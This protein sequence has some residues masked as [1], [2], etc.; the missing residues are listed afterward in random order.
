MHQIEIQRVTLQDVAELQKIGRETFLETFGS[1]NTEANMQQYLAEGFSVEKL[2]AEL[3]HP[4]SDFY[5]AKQDRMTIGYLKLNMGAAQTELQDD[6]SLEIERIYV[7]SCFHGKSIGQQL[8]THALQ[9][10]REHHMESV[11]LGVWEENPRAI[12]FYRK[13]GFLPFGQHVF[14]LGDDVQTDVMMRL[15]ALIQPF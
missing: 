6:K 7:L 10:A 4:Q 9:I 8:Y 2:T 15:W 3:S 1:V 13:N 14:R 11:W 12:A 5:F